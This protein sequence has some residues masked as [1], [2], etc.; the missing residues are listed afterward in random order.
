[1]DEQGS[2]Q[3]NNHEITEL[4]LDLTPFMTFSGY[5]SV[6]TLREAEPTDIDEVFDESGAMKRVYEP[7]IDP[8]SPL[9]LHPSSCFQEHRAPFIG[10]IHSENPV[11]RDL[12]QQLSLLLQKQK[13]LVKWV[14]DVEAAA[15]ADDSSQVFTLLATLFE[16]ATI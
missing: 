15:E 12:V 13:D 14:E 9:F 6:L 16:G 3:A 2:W 4:G 11:Q 7:L 8:L 5:D 1:M 10:F